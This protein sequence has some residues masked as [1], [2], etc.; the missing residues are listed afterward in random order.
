M[1]ARSLLVDMRVC[2][3]PVSHMHLVDSTLFYSPT[4]G[5]VKRYLTAKHSWL[6]ARTSWEHTIIVPGKANHVERGGV[7]T[8]AGSI[9]PGTFN[10]R[11]PLDPR[12]WIDLM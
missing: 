6:A 11:M 9:V 5:G 10:Y 3:T 8:L 4:S 1:Q 7:C 2:W 12:R